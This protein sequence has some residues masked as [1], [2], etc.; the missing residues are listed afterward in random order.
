MSIIIHHIFL[1]R[2]QTRFTKIYMV[3]KSTPIFYHIII[4]LC[5]IGIL[6]FPTIVT[7]LCFTCYIVFLFIAL[8]QK[9][10]A[11]FIIFIIIMNQLILSKISYLFLSVIFRIFIYL[12]QI[13]LGIQSCLNITLNQ[14]T[15]SFI[16]VNPIDIIVI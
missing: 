12:T 1:R 10:T 11:V 8:G 13:I 7:Q 6:I 14:I 15:A 4:K 3:I 5:Q 16:F 2:F 9:W